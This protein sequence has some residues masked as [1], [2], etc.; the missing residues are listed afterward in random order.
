MSFCSA[1]C[2]VLVLASAGQTFQERCNQSEKLFKEFSGADEERKQA[3]DILNKMLTNPADADEELYARWKLACWEFRCGD[4]GRARDMLEEAL[5]LKAATEGRFLTFEMHRSLGEFYIEAFQQQPARKHMD[6]A[7]KLAKGKLSFNGKPNPVSGP[8]LTFMEIRKAEFETF[9][10]QDLHA[11]HAAFSAIRTKIEDAIV[12]DRKAERP[13]SVN[14]AILAAKCDTNLAD[15]DRR[16]ANP[17]GAIQRLTTCVAYLKPHVKH[18]AVEIQFGCHINLATNYCH[19]TRF[20]DARAELA[21]AAKLL[22]RI[23]NGRNAGDLQ[24]AQAVVRIDECFFR[25]EQD[26]RDPVIL[27]RLDE[28]EKHAGAALDVYTQAS[29]GKDNPI[30]YADLALGEVQELRAGVLEA[31]GISR[32]SLRGQYQQAKTYTAEALQGL[33]TTLPA[34]DD[35]VLQVQRRLAGLYLKLDDIPARARRRRTPLTASGSGTR[36]E[37]EDFVGRGLFH[38]LLLEIEDHADN[39]PGVRRHAEDHR[40]LS[41]ERLVAYLAPLTATEQIKFFR[42]WD[43]PGL[44]AC[45]RLGLHRPSLREASAE[46]LINGKAKSAEVLAAVNLQQRGKKGYQEFQRAIAEQAYLLYGPAA[47]NAA[48]RL[49]EIES[50]KQKLAAGQAAVP[51]KQWYT[52]GHLREHLA[53]DEVYIDICCL[54]PAANATRVY[55]AWVVTKG[56]ADVVKLGDA[57]PIDYLVKVF[58]QHMESCPGSSGLF[59]TLGP[60]EAESKLRRDCLEPLSDLLLKPLLPLVAGKKRWVISPDGPLWNVPWGALMLPSSDCYALEK[61]TFRY[62]VSGRDLVKQLAPEVQSGDPWILANPDYNRGPAGVSG[63]L[64]PKRGDRL[65]VRDLPGARRRAGWSPIVSSRSSRA[66]PVS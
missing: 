38:H 48:T 59:A 60:P 53:A 34:E 63:G 56:T 21:E 5:K 17:F 65:W 54:R 44:H 22:P 15:L 40:R 50:N 18:E 35:I 32:E 47:G 45:L 8:V 14:W 9:R 28:A 52:L 43:D 42:M 2:L 19:L 4:T 61:Y 62:V 31:K 41:A 26:P 25:F 24:N 36:K 39:L 64:R 1:A 11:A 16:L 12:R 7:L 55:H 3:L 27:Q 58:Q 51:P 6:E 10:S 20:A 33:R 37:E 46:W 57:E 29:Q 13:T 30:A 49:L 23:D 66:K